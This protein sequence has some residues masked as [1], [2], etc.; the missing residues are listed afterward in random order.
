[1]PSTP[2][3][4]STP[5]GLGVKED[6]AAAAH[7]F[8]AAAALGNVPARG[9][10]R[11][12]PV[13]RHRRRPRIEAGAV[14]WF[15]RAAEA[16]NPVAQNRLARILA[17]GAGV[18]ADPVAAAKWHYLAKAHGKTDEWLDSFVDGLTDEQRQTAA[19]AAQRW[20]AN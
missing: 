14:R 17:V 6:A 16:G 7:W 3:P 8:A 9:R 13:Q 18:P 19:A 11:H 1:M 5:Q 20:P 4:S 12:P 2:S 10:I 15:E